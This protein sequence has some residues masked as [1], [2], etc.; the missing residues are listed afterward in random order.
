MKVDLKF[1][2]DLHMIH[3]DK[4]EPDTKVATPVF[5]GASEEE[6]TGLLEHGL[7]NRDGDRL[8]DGG[9]KVAVKQ[10]IQPLPHTV[11]AVSPPGDQR[12]IH[13]AVALFCRPD[14]AFFLQPVEK[15]QHRGCC[16]DRKSV[17]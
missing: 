10:G 13:V 12:H 2:D 6:I 8:M 7:P 17:V 9:G 11:H 14:P 5:D 3:A 15:I 16:P 1:A 4:A